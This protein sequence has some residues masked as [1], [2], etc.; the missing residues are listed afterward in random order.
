MFPFVF[1]FVFAFECAFVFVCMPEVRTGLG[2]MYGYSE[3]TQ[4]VLG[5]TQRFSR[6]FE[7][8]QKGDQ[9]V[10]KGL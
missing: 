1:A 2:G 10:I 5:G 7:A 4:W 8:Y 3:G 9:G 6:D